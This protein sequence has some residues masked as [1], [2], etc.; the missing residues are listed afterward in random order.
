MQKHGK[1]FMLPIEREDWLLQT[2]SQLKN[3]TFYMILMDQ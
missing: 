3:S 2:S 1:S